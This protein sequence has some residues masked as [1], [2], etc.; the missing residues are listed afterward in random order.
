[1]RRLFEIIRRRGKY[2]L[3]CRRNPARDRLLPF[4]RAHVLKDFDA[5]SQIEVAFY[6]LRQAT[7]GAV[8]ADISSHFG[9]GE[10]GNVTP[11]GFYTPIPEGLDRAAHGAASVKY[12]PRP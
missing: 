3:V 8:G 9:D 5:G 7:D 6:G 11:R 4:V 1:M 2:D 10:L 12:A